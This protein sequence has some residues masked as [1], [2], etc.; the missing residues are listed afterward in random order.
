[1]HNSYKEKDVGY[2]FTFCTVDCFIHVCYTYV[3]RSIEIKKFNE[4]LLIETLRPNFYSW[5]TDLHISRVQ[6]TVKICFQNLKVYLEANDFA[7]Y[8]YYNTNNA[9]CIWCF[10]YF[11]QF[12]C[13]LYFRL[14]ENVYKNLL[15]G[16]FR[17]FL[18]KNLV[19]CR[20]KNMFAFGFGLNFVFDTYISHCI[21]PCFLGEKII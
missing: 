8:V 14:L 13:D 2:I 7:I 11:Q 21:L 12:V 5:L 18:D 3:F 16:L 10:E 17:Y 9:M 20:K 19:R 6:K 15:S 4:D 1:M